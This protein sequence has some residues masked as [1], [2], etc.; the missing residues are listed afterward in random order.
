MI[1][2]K[3]TT[4]VPKL[5]LLFSFSVLRSGFCWQ[6][7]LHHPL[8]PCSAEPTCDSAPRTLHHDS[9]FS[10]SSRNVYPGRPIAGGRL[11]GIASIRTNLSTM[12]EF[13]GGLLSIF[14]TEGFLVRKDSS[15]TFYGLLSGWHLWYPVRHFPFCND[16][17]CQSLLLELRFWCSEHQT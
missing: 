10:N 7:S 6:P 13:M 9:T 2:I 5:F 17:T 3:T 15:R 14:G 11:Y 12:L 8:S 1:L 4:G 16:R